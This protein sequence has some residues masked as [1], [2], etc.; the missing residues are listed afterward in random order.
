MPRARLANQVSD[1]G[2]LVTFAVRLD[3]PEMLTLLLDLGFDPDERP[4]PAE[5]LGKPLEYLPPR[6][7]RVR[8][9]GHPAATRRHAAA[10]ERPSPSAKPT[11]SVRSTRR[12]RSRTR[13]T[14]TVC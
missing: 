5:P 8:P 1:V 14:A 9:G 12:E 3:R 10:V 2:G 7:Q 11:G 6:M 4:D 13:R